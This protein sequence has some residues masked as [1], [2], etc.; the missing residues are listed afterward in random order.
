[1]GLTEKKKREYLITIIQKYLE[2]GKSL[3]EYLKAVAPT[4]S[5]KYACNKSINKIDEAL[6]HLRQINHIEVLEHLYSMFIGNGVIAYSISGGIIMSKEMQK[7][8]TDEGIHEL[9]ELIEENRKKQE[10]KLKIQQEN[11]KIVEQAKKEGKKVEMVYDKETK[12]VKPM[13]V[14]E[15][16]NA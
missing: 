14:E 6:V 9:I 10:E 8:D 12:S 13:I 1:M 7:W 16:N 15:N 4:R 3:M 2:T 5:A 11:R